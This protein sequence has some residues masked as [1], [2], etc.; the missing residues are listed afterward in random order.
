MTWTAR[1]RLWTLVLIMAFALVGQSFA[2][3]AMEMRSEA[4]A[5]TATS[6][7]HLCSGCVRDMSKG[8]LA[9]CAGFLCAGIIAILPTVLVEQVAFPSVFPRIADAKRRGI[10]VPPPLGPP[11]SLHF[12]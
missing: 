10:A 4:S 2:P 5:M 1:N 7:S 6:P 9:D 11:R 12:A 3:A 8:A